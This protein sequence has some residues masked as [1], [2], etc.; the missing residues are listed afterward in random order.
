MRM[1]RLLTARSRTP[2]TGMPNGGQT[3]DPCVRLTFPRTAFDGDGGVGRYGYH[4]DAIHAQFKVFMVRI[5]SL[6]P[7]LRSVS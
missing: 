6:L 2:L 7:D 4:F 1:W 5:A 3:G